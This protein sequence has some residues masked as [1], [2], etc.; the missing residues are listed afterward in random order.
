MAVGVSRNL[1][2]WFS[3][4]TCALLATAAL[5]LAHADPQTLSSQ[6]WQ[7]PMDGTGLART[8]SGRLLGHLTLDV[9]LWGGYERNPLILTDRRRPMPGPW[10]DPRNPLSQYNPF[11]R[12]VGS[13]LTDRLAS[14][15]TVSLG[16]FNW[17]QLYAAVPVTLW[18]QRGQG[19]SQATTGF[20]PL[21]ETNAGDLRLGGKI[22]LLRTRDFFLLPDV[23]LVS[24]LVLPVGLGFHSVRFNGPVPTLKLGTAGWAQGYTSEG[25]PSLI[26]ELAVSRELF[27]LFGGVNAGV[28]IRRPYQLL[29]LTISHEALLRAGVGFKGRSLA[30]H[31][32]FMRFFPVE[33]GLEAQASNALIHP[34]VTVPYLTP[35]A[36]DSGPTVVS[37]RFTD[38]L[39]PSLELSGFVGVDA[40][41]F[42][43]YVGGG[44]GVL[45]TWGTPEWRLTGG[46]RVVPS[47]LWE[48][49]ASGEDA[50]RDRDGV[51]DR[52]DRCPTVAGEPTLAGCPDADRDGV[53]DAEDR[54]PWEPRGTV[55]DAD[56]CPHV[57]LLA[58]AGQP[59][60]VAAN[61]P[62]ADGDGIP[63]SRD[64]CPRRAEDMDG[65]SDDD[66]CP[67]PDNDDDGVADELDLCPLEA[68]VANGLDDNDGCPDLDPDPDS[69][70]SD[71]DAFDDDVDRCPW[72]AGI[73]P[74][75][76]P[77]ADAVP[78][79]ASKPAQ[80]EE[81]DGAP[82]PEPP[83]AAELPPFPP[84]PPGRPV[85][86]RRQQHS[87]VR[88]APISI[89]GT[90]LSADP[91]S[92]IDHDGIADMVDACPQRAEDQDGFEDED[93]CP[94]LDNDDDG[95]LDVQDACPLVADDAWDGDGC[96]RE[97]PAPVTPGDADA[98]GVGDDADLCPYEPEDANGTRDG[99]GCPEGAAPLPK[100]PVVA[101]AA[102]A[103]AA[104]PAVEVPPDLDG[105]GIPDVEDACPA[106]A[107]DA[108]GFADEDGCPDPDND[109]DG[110]L[111]A[112]DRCP[113][114]AETRNGWQDD[115]GCPDE[116]PDADGDKVPDRLDRCPFDPE[117]HNGLRDDDGCPDA[118][119]SG[120]G[121]GAVTLQ[122][123]KADADTPKGAQMTEVMPWSE[124]DA[125]GDG[126]PSREDMC[127]RRAEDK[128]G[129]ADEDGCP[130]ADA[131]QDGLVD[132]EDRCPLEAETFNGNRDTDGC[133]D[134]EKDQDDDGVMDALDRCPLEAGD[135][136]SQDPEAEGS[137]GC[138]HTPVVMSNRVR[139]TAAIPLRKPSAAAVLQAAALPWTPGD[140]DGDGMAND[141]DP[142]PRRAEDLDGVEDDDGCPEPDNDHDGIPD[143]TDR[144]PM[145]A[146]VINGV[147]DDDGCPDAGESK[148][149]M[150]ATRVEIKEKV[151]FALGTA[152]L[153]RRSHGLL[154]QVAALLKA[155]PDVHIRVEGHTDNIGPDKKNMRLS[156]RRAEAVVKFLIK[157]RIP[158]QRLKAVGYGP[159]RPVESNLTADGREANR[160]VEFVVVEE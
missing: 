72:E 67:E 159:G 92:D 90:A 41:G 130:D 7:T 61:E 158:K 70:D 18:Q 74:D 150:E 52:K 136:D 106:R 64:P 25:F 50:D 126:V 39:Q 88:P 57:G 108:D 3:G 40:L 132:D 35:G 122:P 138:P 31:L 12:R 129:F 1:T 113:L 2:P 154:R 135:H 103:P 53:A 29:Q 156:Q 145:E 116:D 144:C 4:L 118:P 139:G 110:L 13:L 89:P 160:R 5:P 128:N 38:M 46:I 22:R 10:S 104:A 153:S 65:F 151:Y 133:P 121:A 117:D 100:A 83:D 58:A 84:P 93:G 36:P 14:E 37:P 23:A 56:G 47:E 146:E 109:D 78:Q 111:D 94:D 27:G 76:C 148:V 54:C 140:A 59:E 6:R 66:G 98:D 20:G 157:R 99:D 17:V 33:A 26:T 24:Q 142:C 69:R 81:P 137:D 155:Y 82:T 85:G 45:S 102:P 127:P 15:A 48:V 95:I 44:M 107:E 43:P 71:H 119:P 96:P 143:R 80:A 34:Y 97:V 32:S 87:A 51:P 28:R 91:T 8:H 21:N 114:E 134:L 112:A 152:A 123:A 147:K 120:A 105:D 9:G 73:G 16:L 86:G 60:P 55:D 125:D 30:R 62:D 124:G 42:H 49:V 101:A 11:Q 149:A 131:D 79:P 68:E 19:I 115:D 75:G 77:H 63:D 141:V